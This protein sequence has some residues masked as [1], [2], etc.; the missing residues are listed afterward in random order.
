M[1]VVNT[2]FEVR[3]TFLNSQTLF[4]QHSYLTKIEVTTVKPF[5]IS[6]NLDEG[7]TLIR[8]S[9][10]DEKVKCQKSRKTF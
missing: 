1:R 2:L 5:E 6:V 10:S 8:N 4:F 3:S 7:T 9:I